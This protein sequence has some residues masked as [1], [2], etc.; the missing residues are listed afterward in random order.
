M[1]RYDIVN[2]V[3]ELLKT[4]PKAASRSALLLAARFSH[5]TQCCPKPLEVKVSP[6]VSQVESFSGM[7][8]PKRGGDY[9]G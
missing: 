1:V 9:E 3:P 4:H 7:L 6:Q 2:L 8:R 5:A